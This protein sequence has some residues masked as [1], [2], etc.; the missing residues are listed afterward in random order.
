MLNL[1]PEIHWALR[2]R[3]LRC[4]ATSKPGHYGK[5]SG[6]QSMSRGLASRVRGGLV[7]ELGCVCYSGQI[8]LSGLPSGHPIESSPSLA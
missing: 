4:F 2:F 1:E 8:V 3:V 7:V 5:A 6:N